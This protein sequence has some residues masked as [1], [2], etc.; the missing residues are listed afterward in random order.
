MKTSRVICVSAFL[1]LFGTTGCA[2]LAKQST[3]SGATEG[4]RLGLIADT[5]VTTHERTS[6][7]LFR[8]MRADAVANVAVRTAAQENLSVE[9]L[10]LLL[11]DVAANG[12][13]AILYLGDGA[14]SGCDDELGKFFGK[15][16]EVRAKTTVPV[17]FVV[18]NHDYLA[19]GNQAHPHQ[20]S[21]ACGGK[22]Y[23][24]KA[25]LVERV[26]K[27][28]RESWTG[29][30]QEAGVFDN[31]VDSLADVT[32]VA[33]KACRAE[34]HRQHVEGC[35]YAA[36]LKFEKNGAAGELI[37]VD[38]SDY[39]GLRFNPAMPGSPIAEVRGLRGGVS[40]LPGGQNDWIVA[41]VEADGHDI[42]YLASHYPTRDLN[43]GNMPSGRLGDLLAKDATNVWLSA[44][45][46]ENNPAEA[47]VCGLAYSRMF[48]W[49]AR[50]PSHDEVNVGSTTDHQ[51][52]G[53]IV[54]VVG[55]KVTKT[56]VIALDD[57]QRKS[58]R[59]WLGALELGDEYGEPIP[60]GSG[61]HVRLGLTLDYRKGNYASDVVRAN[62]KQLLK[63]VGDADRERTVR[64]LMS[65]AAEA[66][67]RG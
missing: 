61:T 52:H 66:E 43:W 48:Q 54:D 19:T 6:G 57:A 20:R 22:G 23:A 12:P 46:H 5:Q 58:C 59:D 25:D 29:F 31:Y 41:Q 65:V 21:L 49:W 24:T 4:V 30:A 64:C 63:D 38:T 9:H 34:E 53:A 45:T 62:I 55:G 17:F 56:P 8:T 39:E 16:E 40:H 27:F 14:N 60:G 35:F 26:A 51:A 37:L 18:G 13:D 50:S 28:N 42:R 11:H 15:L 7:Y 2:T 47:V 67:A 44:H 32:A 1:A 33:G 36:V 3:A 10:G